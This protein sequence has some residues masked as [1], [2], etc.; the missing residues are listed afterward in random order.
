MNAQMLE[1]SLLGVGTLL[2][3]EEDG[4][5][6]IKRLRQATNEYAAPPPTRQETNGNIQEIQDKTLFE[7]KGRN[8]TH[9]FPRLRRRKCPRPRAVARKRWK[10]PQLEG[11]QRLRG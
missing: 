10:E 3:L 2:R 8:H 1:V 5:S 9:R 6:T 7:N 11:E 4:W